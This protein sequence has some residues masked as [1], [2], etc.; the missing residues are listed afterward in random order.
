M[1]GGAGDDTYV[2]DA[3]GDRIL[4]FA[5]EGFDLVLASASF[6]LAAQLES[7]TMTGAAAISGTGNDLANTLIGNIAANGLNGGAG[8]DSMAGGAGDDTYTVDDAGDV[9]TEAANEGLDTVRA[10]VSFTLGENVERLVLTGTAGIAGTGNALANALTGNAAANLLNGGDG[11]DT[12]TGGAGD[13]TLDGGTAV[14]R[15]VGGDGDDTYVVDAA[16]EVVLELPAGGFDQVFA[17]VAFTLS[18]EVEKLTLTGTAAVAGT[19][20]AL[21]N[22]IIGNDGAN[23]LAG[24]LGNDSLSGGLGNDTLVGGAGADTLAGGAGADTF[25]FDFA[26]EGGDTVLGYQGV[27]DRFQI[28]ASGFGGGLVAGSN[29]VTTGHYVANVGGNAVAATGQFA[30]DTATS[31]LW[32]DADGTGLGDRVMLA[33]LVGATGWAGSELTLIA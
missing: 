31:T 14:D 7:L 2:V 16:G 8:A 22:E 32:W 24:G 12:L 28:S 11:N 23:R 26:T 1:A 29:I 4:E 20:N 30:F 19:G 21:D 27:E 3:T 13:D 5:G 6:T 18:A 10:S 33:T 25:R 15:M 9:V 17:S